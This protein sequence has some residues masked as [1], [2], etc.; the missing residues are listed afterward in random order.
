ML[1]A[2]RT[3]REPMNVRRAVGLCCGFVLVSCSR[4]PSPSSP[5]PTGTFSYVTR[6]GDDTVAVEEYRRTDDHVDAQIMQRSPMTYVAR[7]RIDLT[8]SG[9]ATRWTFDPRLVSG[10]RPPSA[11]SRLLTFSL[12]ST[13]IVSDTGAQF[14]RHTVPGFG[15]PQVSNSMLTYQLAIDYARSIGRDSVLVPMVTA[16]GGHSNL[17]VRFLGRDS[18]RTYYGGPEWPIYIT[19]DPSGRIVTLDARATTNKIYSTRVSGI[20]VRTIASRY[21]V[22]DQTSGAMGTASPR[23]TVRADVQG[24]RLSIDYSRPALRGR[25]VWSNGVLGDTLWRTG[26]NAAT[27]FT[28]DADLMIGTTAIPA[29]KYTLWTHV[30]PGNARYELIFNR[31]V[32]QWGAGPNT[33]EMKNDLARVPLVVKQMPT[34]SERFTL[35]IEPVADG[36]VLAMQWGTTRLET[37]FSIRR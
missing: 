14:T 25:N 29:G 12:D 11:P 35:S 3:V 1:I 6:L 8:S 22:R 19:L 4:Q 13:I 26:A 2:S 7:S 37:P 16:A 18:V 21:S 28:T 30:F 27:Q 15:V 9:L 23:D 24:H 10:S 31:Q 33:Y 5:T 34:S 20:S 32:G 17:P 36:G